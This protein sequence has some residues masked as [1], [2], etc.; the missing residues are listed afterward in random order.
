M[1]RHGPL[2]CAVCRGGECRGGGNRTCAQRDP[3]PSHIAGILDSYG[4]VRVVVAHKATLKHHV[5]HDEF[6]AVVPD[7]LVHE[8][9]AWGDVPFVVA[10]GSLAVDEWCAKHAQDNDPLVREAV[11]LRG[12]RKLEQDPS[13]LNPYEMVFT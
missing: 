2:S 1:Q 8:P 3:K 5:R 12:L 7:K 4:C 10:L 6:L 11:I 9:I 13:S